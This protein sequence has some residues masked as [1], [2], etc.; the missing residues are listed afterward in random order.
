MNC[1]PSEDQRMDSCNS[2]GCDRVLT[3][4]LHSFV[5]NVLDNSPLLEQLRSS[6]KS[7][8]ND[9][10]S[11]RLR[12]CTHRVKINDTQGKQHQ[13][14]YASL[15]LNLQW[16]EKFR[17]HYWSP[18]PLQYAC[19]GSSPDHIALLP[20]AHLAQSHFYLSVLLELSPAQF[21]QWLGEKPYV[22]LRRPCV[23]SH[24]TIICVIFRYQNEVFIG[25]PNDQ[26]V[27]RYKVPYQ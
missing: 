17:S 23:T 7:K 3:L 13:L 14:M 9:K 22:I 11:K 2:D 21:H 19:S 18:V 25:H 16:R 15:N 12:T 5:S 20:N 24:F 27:T 4:S 10:N 6:N 8:R 26:F 1:F